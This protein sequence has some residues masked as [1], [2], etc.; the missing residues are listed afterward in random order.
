MYINWLE[1][2]QFVAALDDAYSGLHLI[3]PDGLAAALNAPSMAFEY[4]GQ[5]DLAVLS[6]LYAERVAKAHAF[7][8]GNKRA[9]TFACLVFLNMN[10]ATPDVPKAAM[11]D[12]IEKLAKGTQTAENFAAMLDKYTRYSSRGT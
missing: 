1:P 3:R 12:G 8:D 6:A 4:G 2:E 11:A 7:A 9:A 5:S 10:N